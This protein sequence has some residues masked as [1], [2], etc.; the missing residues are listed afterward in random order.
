MLGEGLRRDEGHR[1]RSL[2]GRVAPEPGGR[3]ARG[4]AATTW[5][6]P[7]RLAI[8]RPT[9][10]TSRRASSVATAGPSEA[11]PAE[12]VARSCSPSDPVTL[13][14]SSSRRISSATRWASST[15][16]PS[17]IATNSSPPNRATMSLERRR[18]DRIE[19]KVAQDGVADD[20]A[21]LL[22]ERAEMVEVEQ[23]DRHRAALVQR[24]ARSRGEQP[25]RATPR[26]GAGS[27]DPSAGRG[28]PRRPRARAGRR[29]RA[30]A[31]TCEAISG[32]ASSS[33]AVKTA[34]QV[35]AV[36]ADRADD[37]ILVSGAG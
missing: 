13:H 6:R 5:L 15:V 14:D 17:R 8:W 16:A 28:W 18:P 3:T 21:V 2:A 30:R 33:S 37:D 31:S 32:I 34:R 23:D 20:V 19:P 12:T 25:R 11:H 9:S 36:D 27:R 22:V 24:E 29:W 35:A 7:P 4:Q 26:G 1:S 10:A